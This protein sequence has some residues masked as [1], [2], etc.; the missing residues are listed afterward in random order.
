MSRVGQNRGYVGLGVERLD[1][2]SLP[3]RKEAFNISPNRG[4]Y[5]ERAQIYAKAGC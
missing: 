2:T 3:D 5:I 4:R 1:T